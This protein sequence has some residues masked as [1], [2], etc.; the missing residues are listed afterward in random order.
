MAGSVLAVRGLFPLFLGLALVVPGAAFGEVVTAAAGAHEAALG[1]RPDGSPVVGYVE[2][3]DVVL[4]TRTA[5]GWRS[6]TIGR[7][8]F[9]GRVA[10]LLYGRGS[11]LYVL[12]E[13]V[14]YGWLRLFVRFGS[15]WRSLVLRSRGFGGPAGLTI[16]RAGRAVVAYATWSLSP[17][18]RST[19]FLVREQANGRLVTRQVTRNGFPPASSPPSATPVV[20]ADGSLRILEAVGGGSGAVVLSWRLER[21]RWWGKVVYANAIGLPLGPAFASPNGQTLDAAWSVL[22]AN[23][24]IEQVD[25]LVGTPYPVS[26]SA[27]A[28]TNAQVAGLV[29]GVAGIELAA[30]ER[31]A[32]LFAGR[33]LAGDAMTELDGPLL[34]FARGARD[35]RQL[36]GWRDAQ[37]EWFETPALLTIRV[38][39]TEP[40]PG[41]LAGRVA[42][43]SAGTVAIYDEA[44]RPRALVA[45]V[46]IATDGTFTLSAP[47]GIYRAVYV[48]PATGVPYAAVKR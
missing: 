42:G 12:V 19:L 39:L 40:V 41:T 45:T 20:L 3:R 22:Y 28:L 17:S 1:V 24:G 44:A 30:N 34:G 5:A 37:L 36:L 15:R 13:H 29:R 21:G 11:R 33:V 25:A 43:A 26:R 10:R 4:A 2:G 32:G 47:S 6:Q 38:T 48:D 16:D 18:S 46:P 9:T 27:V 8:P 7:A 35:S 23:A 14:D 31:V